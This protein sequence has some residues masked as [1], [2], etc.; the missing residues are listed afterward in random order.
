MI[1]ISDVTSWDPVFRVSIIFKCQLD[2][3]TSKEAEQE[4]LVHP[5]YVK[6]RTTF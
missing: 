2:V 5:T 6:H 4:E 3:G 1:F